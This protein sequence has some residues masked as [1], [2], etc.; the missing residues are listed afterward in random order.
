ML[1]FS[2][3]DEQGPARDFALVNAYLVGP[4]DAALRG[5]ITFDGGEIVC[6]APAGRATG[7][8]LQYD[9]GGAGRLILQTCLL[10]HADRPYVLSLELARHRIKTFLVKCEEWQM[11]ELAL[12]HPAI[13]LWEEA[14]QLFTKGLNER[15]PIRMDKYGRASLQRAIEAT[16]RLAMAH[17]EILLHRRYATKPA[18]NTTLGVRVSPQSSPEAFADLLT[19]EFDLLY[20]PVVWRDIERAEGEYDWTPI[21]RW[22]SFAQRSRKPVIAGPLLDFSQSAVPDFLYVWQNDYDTT[23]DL[24]YDHIARV[25]NRYR[26]VVSMWSIAAGINTNSNFAF[27][28]SQMMDLTRMANLLIRQELRGRTLLEIVQPFGE[29]VAKQRDAISPLA[30]IDRLTQEGIRVH[31][32]GLRLAFGNGPHGMAARDLMQVSDILDRYFL[33]ELPVLIT[34]AGVP[35]EWRDGDACGYWRRPWTSD[36]QANWAA[37]AFPMFMSKPHVESLIWIALE[38]RPQQPVQNS[39]LLDSSGGQKPAF[40]RLLDIRRRLRKPLGAMRNAA[41]RPIAASDS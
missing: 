34:E 36:V 7:V 25:V 12:D 15:D 32:Y 9:S 22:M 30:Y 35:S 29:F 40:K 11:F 3:F 28:D 39:G 37:R 38:D 14:R 8:A 23:R 17:A 18:S 33:L 13:A 31:A 19:R 6:E 16:E 5:Q 26:K 10:P 21:D 24:A 41:T 27:T 1:R 4:D 2:V 20:I